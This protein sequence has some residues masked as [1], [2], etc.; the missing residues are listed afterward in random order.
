[1]EQK[2]SS[3]LEDYLVAVY[4]LE[5][6]KRVARPRDIG[7]LQNVAKSTV[8]AALKSLAEKRL[9]NYQPYD[10]ITLTPL[11]RRKAEWLAVRNRILRN[12]LESVLALDPELAE[13]TACGMEHAVDEE[14]MERFVCF[15]AFLQ[16]YAP[17]GRKWL[18]EFHA[19]AREGGRSLK[20]RRCVEKYRKALQK[21]SFKDRTV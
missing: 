3:T 9:V 19:F 4:R 14:A 20:C 12:F 2:L 13:T 6:E 1:M 5:G 11:G 15:L 17:S 7:R 16:Q 10:P 18:K 8:T 21:E